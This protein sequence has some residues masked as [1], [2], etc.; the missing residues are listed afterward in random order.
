M[1][2]PSVTYTLTN[3]T[4]A[5]ASQVMQNFN[6][7]INGMSDGT[8]DLSI[9]ALTLAGALT[10]N[11]HVNIGNASADDLIVNASLASNLVPKTT[12]TYNLGSADVGVAGVYFGT[13]D[14]DTAR[15]VSAAL[16]ADRTYTLPDAGAAADFVM[17]AGATAIT[18]LKTFQGG[19][20][21]A[22]Y[23]G[24]VPEVGG[25]SP[26]QLT[27]A[28]KR[29]QVV[30]D[31][32]DVNLP[33]TSV[34][35]GESWTIENRSSS[36]LDING[37]DGSLIVTIRTGYAVVVALQDTPTANS[38]WRLTTAEDTGSF[39]G[40]LTGCTTSPT[41]TS[42]W[43]RSGKGV[44]I[45]I[46]EIVG[47][48]NATSATITGLPASLFPARIQYVA[49]YTFDNGTA[50]WEKWTVNTAGTITL[51][52]SLSSTGFTASGTKGIKEAT[53]SFMVG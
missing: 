45:F 1:P 18:G 22:E 27:V 42:Y 34:K 16:A 15:I 31:G 44:T 25:S 47:T 2:A 52:K 5:D 19:L 26:W 11:G 3:G 53:V 49:S 37:S 20:S 24:T 38:H 7:L 43:S 12:N 4:T 51:F 10:A 6:D 30:N 23:V 35:A 36:D 29:V 9:N 17:T 50:T 14:T 33:T 48:S 40:T 41:G 32:G 21:S 13:A 39:T 28:H 8:K 46:P